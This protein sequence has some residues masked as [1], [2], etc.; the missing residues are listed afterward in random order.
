MRKLGKH[1]IV[2]L[3]A[4]GL[5][6][7][8]VPAIVDTNSVTA[9]AA[10]NLSFRET[11]TDGESSSTDSDHDYINVGRWTTTVKS[12]LEETENGYCRV[13]A[14][15]KNNYVVVEEYSKDYRQLSQ[16]KIPYEL[17]I[18][19][20][21][22]LGDNYRFLV[23]GQENRDEDE[24]TEVIRIVKYDKSWNQLGT[25]SI[26]DINT[27]VP[28]D[29]GSLRM[30]ESG[31]MLYI[32]T[33]HEMYKSSDGRNH[34]ANMTFVMNQE[35]MEVTQSWYGVMNIGYGYVSHSFNQF[36]LTDGD[37]LYRLDHGDAYPRAV[38]LT[39]ADTNNITS[40]ANKKILS[41]CGTIGA[42]DTGVEVGGFE[43]A[44]GQLVVAGN[45]VSQD[46]EESYNASGVKNVFIASTDTD[47]EST[48]TTWLTGYTERDKT[49][50]GNPHLVKVSEEELYVLWEELNSSDGYNVKIAQINN[51]GELQGRV[52]T[53]KARLSDCAPVFTSGGE[54][55][56]YV[57]FQYVP[58]LFHIAPDKLEEYEK[59]EEPA[60]GTGG[61]TGDNKPGNGTGGTTGGSKNKTSKVT[62]PSKVQKVTAKNKK[63]KTVTLS[64]KKVSGAKGYQFQ[65]AL[66]KKFTK[67]KK[68]KLTTK[69]KVTIKKLKKKKTYYFRV[70]AYKLN[71]KTKVYGKWSSVKKV[72]IKK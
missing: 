68:S 28:F 21:Y 34:Q 20:G 57:T 64:W 62:A 25:L 53:L 60:S 61:T 22:F 45:S 6:I 69:T 70:R 36:V 17:P 47:L 33:C 48:E 52:Y 13:E 46:D 7:N 14:I 11:L 10:S 5:V 43:M 8:S 27:T 63:N 30:A 59:M 71:G 3:T 4:L 37:Y 23:F 66:N 49:E 50:V 41:I 2:I 72:K 19:G 9:S 15:A 39:K 67:S 58:D 40:C 38:V 32:H 24:S 35:T 56:W 42:N 16:K 1:F 44:G 31:G 26:S 65:Y 12:Y 54:I 55:A 51:M 29:A 18:F